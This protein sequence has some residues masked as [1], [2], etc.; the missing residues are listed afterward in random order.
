MTAGVSSQTNSQTDK[1]CF[2]YVTTNGRILVVPDVDQALR[3][4]LKS[5]N[6]LDALE[7]TAEGDSVLNM[8]DEIGLSAVNAFEPKLKD[9]IHYAL[10][11]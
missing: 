6:L 4:D 9:F 3:E 7:R 1:F 5:S 11:S 2:V 10:Y 8:I